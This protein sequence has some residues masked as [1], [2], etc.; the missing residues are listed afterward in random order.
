MNQQKIDFSFHNLVLLPSFSRE[1]THLNISNNYLN[2]L[3][4]NL[5]NIVVLNASFNRL[6]ICE[7]FCA[8]LTDV[9]LGYNPDLKTAILPPSI[10][11]LN[12]IQCPVNIE[13]A[14]FN[15]QSLQSDYITDH[16]RFPLLQVYN[17]KIIRPF[18]ESGSDDNLL[19]LKQ[20][21]KPVK[22]SIQEL[23]IKYENKEIEFSKLLES[24]SFCQ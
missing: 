4:L 11:I 5:P 22:Y 21:I 17:T 23:A 10:K 20:E 16:S 9:H 6:E 2:S 18:I 19:E 1:V 8:T 14:K 13:N 12:I 24:M 7:L 15:L 3:I